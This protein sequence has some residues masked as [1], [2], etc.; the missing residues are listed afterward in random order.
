MAYFED[1]S[2]Y[3][4]FAEAD[5]GL[6]NVGWLAK[7]YQFPKGALQPAFTAKLQT[8]PVCMRTRG[9]HT[10]PF[11][12]YAEAHG[13]GRSASSSCE[14]RVRHLGVLYAAPELIKH[15]VSVHAY[16]PPSVFVLAVLDGQPIQGEH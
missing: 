11:C 14:V 4:Y 12:T 7:E 13:Y 15:Y 1:L 3:T 2:P 6:V 9:W 10:C 8:L 5:S 16:R